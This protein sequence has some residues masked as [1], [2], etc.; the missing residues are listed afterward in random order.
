[1]F[2]FKQKI[3]GAA[4]N[5]GTKSVEIMGPLKYQINFW[6]T[7]KIPSTNCEIKHIL[8]LILNHFCYPIC[9]KMTTMFD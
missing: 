9:G 4:V 8:T 7:L 3:T 6:R 1:M 5:N 2:K